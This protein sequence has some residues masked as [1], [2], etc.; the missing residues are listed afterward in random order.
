MTCVDPTD[1][2]ILHLSHL[3]G[4]ALTSLFAEESAAMQSTLE[5]ATTSQPDYSL[6]ICTES[7]SLLRQLNVGHQ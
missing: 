2:I 3:R 6:T 7:Q 5:W 4:V 1:P